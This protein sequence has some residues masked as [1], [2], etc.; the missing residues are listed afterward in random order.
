MKLFVLKSETIKI[1]TVLMYVLFLLNYL[2]IA[3]FVFQ[4]L[5]FMCNL[6]VSEMVT[7]PPSAALETQAKTVIPL[8]TVPAIQGE[9][10]AQMPETCR[11][12]SIFLEALLVVGA[13]FML[14]VYYP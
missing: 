2:E 7:A 11:L 13:S 10:S 14:M 6:L 12:G 9:A 5:I 8:P 1:A 3:M 4:P